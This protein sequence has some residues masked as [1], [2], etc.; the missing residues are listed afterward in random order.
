MMN[1]QQQDTQA[2]ENQLMQLKAKLYDA[3]EAL[4]QQS[5]LIQAI[6]QKVGF[7]GQTLPELLEAIPA[8]QADKPSA[9]PAIPSAVEEK[10]PL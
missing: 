5:A 6:A 4:Q 9:A 7:Q 3:N 10:H 1:N 8:P 2:V